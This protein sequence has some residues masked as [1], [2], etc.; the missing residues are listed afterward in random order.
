MNKLNITDKLDRIIDRMSF[1]KE[2]LYEIDG[3]E[4]RGLRTAFE[5][6]F[7]MANKEINELMQFIEENEFEP[8]DIV[9][10]KSNK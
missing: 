7:E 8:M 6:E 10:E 2:N 5:D 9:P 4:Y 1:C 3:M